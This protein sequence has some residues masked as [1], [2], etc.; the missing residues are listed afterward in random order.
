M[1]GTTFPARKPL[2]YVHVW[3]NPYYVRLGTYQATDTVFPT[4]EHALDELVHS[5]LDDERSGSYVE[6][7]VRHVD[8]HC[9]VIDLRAEAEA[10]Q[11]ERQKQAEAERADRALLHNWRAGAR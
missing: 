7:L 10:I 4:R 8:G 6:T 1:D 2:Y 9:E 3:T 5:V 11:A